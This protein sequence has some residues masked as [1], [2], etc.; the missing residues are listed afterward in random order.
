MPA[1]SGASA[2]SPSTTFTLDHTDSHSHNLSPKTLWSSCL[3]TAFPVPTPPGA[4]CHDTS[5]TA[6]PVA[7]RHAFNRESLPATRTERLR[8]LVLPGCVVSVWTLLDLCRHLMSLPN[9]PSKP[10]LRSDPE[11]AWG[12]VF[13]GKLRN[14]RGDV[15][16]FGMRCVVRWQ[17]L[18]LGSRRCGRAYVTR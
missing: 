12:L 2:L 8:F 13:A 11:V 5:R 14:E 18:L 1:K 10:I 7:F 4:R 16:G 6:R 17:R 3:Q 15:G 9:L